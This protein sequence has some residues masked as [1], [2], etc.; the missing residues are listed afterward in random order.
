MSTLSSP[1]RWQVKDKPK[2]FPALPDFV[3]LQLEIPPAEPSVKDLQIQDLQKPGSEAPDPFKLKKDLP[4]L[5]ARRDGQGL[6]LTARY[7]LGIITA[8]R[9]AGKWGP[10]SENTIS[11]VARCGRGRVIRAIKEAE[12]AGYV[13]VDRRGKCNWYRVP[14]LLRRVVKIWVNPA[15]VRDDGLSIAVA[16]FVGYVKFR[17]SDNGVTWFTHREFAETLG[18]SYATAYRVAAWGV[19][20]GSVQKRHCPWRRSSKNSYA[21][22][23]QAQAA[24]GVF[25]L[26]SARAKQR[27]LGQTIV[28]GGKS[29]ARSARLGVLPA[30]SGLS[31]DS[32]L[33]GA[34]YVELKNIGV[35][36]RVAR[37][38]AVQWRGRAESVR[39]I[40]IIGL[41]ARLNYLRRMR[42]LRVR[43]NRFNLAGY[44]IRG[45]NMAKAEGHKIELTKAI[46]AEMAKGRGGAHAACDEGVTDPVTEQRREDMKR[47]LRE[48]PAEPITPYSDEELAFIASNRDREAEVARL[49]QRQALAAKRYHGVYK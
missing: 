24:T 35:R 32:R 48:T 4:V 7:I 41:F 40:V 28:E 42:R 14:M 49:R 22:T 43:S 27:A 37:S 12:A 19:A 33:D 29:Y 2:D 45:L 5:C 6:S 15:L 10:L 25:G 46:Q 17:Q 30:D 16:C 23:C 3:N 20:L 36:W 21:L 34:A 39:N 8:Y 47:R 44:V 18:V 11:R 38:I 1:T 31:F 13:D 26:E 9:G